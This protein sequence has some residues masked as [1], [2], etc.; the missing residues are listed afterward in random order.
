MICVDTSVVVAAF[1]P[2]HA[3]HEAAVGVMKGRPSIVS[4][5][6]LEVFSVLT[7]MPAPFRAPADVA[8][9]YL[10]SQFDGR[11]LHPDR[12]TVAALPARLAAL[13]VIGGA[14][15]D[16]LI[17]ETVRVAKGQLVSMDQRAVR[18]YQLLGADYRLLP[19]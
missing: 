16:G 6:L 10:D 2:W 3:A 1:S 11:T 5:C 9:A 19:S 13:G 15:Y 18:T 4:H 12:G 17:A 7:R 8:A 14:A